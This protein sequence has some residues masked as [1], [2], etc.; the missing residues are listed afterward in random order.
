VVVPELLGAGHQ[1]TGLVRSDEA[2]A[3]LAATG[4]GV[5][6]GSLEDLDGLRAGATEAD[7]VIHLAFIH[8][9]SQF[10]TSVQ[11]DRAAIAAFGD[12]LEGTGKPLV[13]AS[14]VLGVW[15]GHLLT[16]D[17][18]PG[19]DA[20]SRLASARDA[21]ALAD[22]GVRSSIVRLAP[23][24]HGPGDHGFVATLAGIARQHGVAGYLEDGSN[25]WPALHRLDSAPL[26]RLA[27]EAAPPGSV[28]HGTAEEGVT[29]RDIATAIG[30]RLDVPVASVPAEEAS[31]HFGWIAMMLSM[32]AP[33]SNALTRELLGWEP[34][35][36][37]L[38]EDIDAGH[39]GEAG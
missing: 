24:V 3:T 31:D 32:D 17:V 23:T 34:M 11:V 1:V 36:P 21:L 15:P 2:A 14:G 19:P 20:A 4:A 8:D 39:Y 9:F 26:F 30:R 5:R 28:L 29:L 7:G 22:R 33:T 35:H 10:D 38:V 13:I 18:R 37:T 6:R 16:E 25:R 12:V 27:A